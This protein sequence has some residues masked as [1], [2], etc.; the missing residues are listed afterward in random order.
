MPDVMVILKKK[1]PIVSNK[2]LR[3]TIQMT[4]ARSVV[5]FLLVNYNVY[6]PIIGH[7]YSMKSFFI[8]YSKILPKEQIHIKFRYTLLIIVISRI[9]S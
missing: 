9:V 4:N 2:K 5:I 8:R 3:H 1:Q 6:W 7:L